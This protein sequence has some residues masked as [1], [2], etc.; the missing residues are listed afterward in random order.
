MTSLESV[1]RRCSANKAMA[2]RHTR[3]GVTWQACSTE[4]STYF[5]SRTYFSL[6][7]GSD[8]CCISVISKYARKSSAQY[9][10]GFQRLKPVNH[11]PTVTFPIQ[12][13]ASTRA[14]GA[15]NVAYAPVSHVVILGTPA[16]VEVRVAIQSLEVLHSHTQYAAHKFRVR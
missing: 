16:P 15:R 9:N 13:Q 6:P 10:R 4:I 12:C 14:G 3:F 8:L 2:A 1:R 5:V 7:M 11:F